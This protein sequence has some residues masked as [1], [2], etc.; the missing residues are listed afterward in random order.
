MKWHTND[1]T[2][3]R[4]GAD[5]KFCPSLSTYVSE[6]DILGPIDNFSDIENLVS[7]ERVMFADYHFKC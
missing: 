2:W 5:H 7:L 1:N 3:V 6:S 4:L